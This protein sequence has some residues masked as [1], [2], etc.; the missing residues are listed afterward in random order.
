[1]KEKFN[2]EINKRLNSKEWN[3]EM[4]H[5]VLNKINENSS[6]LPLSYKLT[7]AALLLF[8]LIISALVFFNTYSSNSEAEF[9]KIVFETN[10]SIIT[11]F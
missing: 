7:F 4:S 5:R 3:F 6:T 10:F 8:S 1:M 2:E 9:T 11:I